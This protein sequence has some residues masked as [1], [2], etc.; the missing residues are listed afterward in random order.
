MGL[1]KGQNPYDT[2]EAENRVKKLTADFIANKT[3]PPS[4]Y[5]SETARNLLRVASGPD[6]DPKIVERAIRELQRFREEPQ[7][8]AFFVEL[9]RIEAEKVFRARIL[10]LKRGGFLKKIGGA[11]GK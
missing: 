5:L 2:V 3:A 11:S 4:P 1:Q 10:A 6:N 9:E 7:V 8:A